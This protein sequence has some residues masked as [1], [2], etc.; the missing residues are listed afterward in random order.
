MVVSLSA[1]SDSETL[2]MITPKETRALLDWGRGKRAAHRLLAGI[3]AK[4]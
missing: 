1:V 4:T 2:I 3:D